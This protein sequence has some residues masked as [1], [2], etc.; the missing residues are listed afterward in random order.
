MNPDA[1]CGILEAMPKEEHRHSRFLRFASLR[2]RAV[3]ALLIVFLPAAAI[4]VGIGLSERSHRIEAV[5]GQSRRLLTAFVAQQDALLDS[6][7]QNLFTLAQDSTVTG[8]DPAACGLALARIRTETPNFANIGV[9]GADG[10]ITCSALPLVEKTSSADRD[11]FKQAVATKRFAVGSYQVGRITGRRALNAA[12]PVLDASGDVRQVV[13]IA[14]DLDWL[15][16][17]AAD[18]GLPD[19]MAFLEVDRGGTVVTRYPEPERYMGMDASATALAQAMLGGERGSVRAT[20]L[21]GKRRT[22]QFAPVGET[23]DARL[24]ASVG[25]DEERV[26]AD[27]DR[28]FSFAFLLLAALGL[29]ALALSL[30]AFRRLLIDPI[31][32]LADGFSRLRGGEYRARLDVPKAHNEMRALAEAFNA[33]AKAMEGHVN[34]LTE[35]DRLIQQLARR[36]EMA[37]RVNRALFRMQDV[38]D[39]FEEACRVGVDVAGFLGAW[40]VVAPPRRAPRVAA[41][42]GIDVASS[43]LLPP[44][45]AAAAHPVARALREGV[46]VLAHEGGRAS[47][48]PPE[49]VLAGAASL[50]AFPLKMDGKPFGAFILASEAA[51]AFHAEDLKLFE[52]LADD[53]AVG[54]AFSLNKAARAHAE[55][56][57][58]RAR[59]RFQ[60]FMDMHPSPAWMT[61]AAG[62][63]VYGN[64]ALRRTLGRPWK[65][66]QGRTVAKLL[67]KKVAETS[68]QGDRKVLES[69]APFNAVEQ[70]TIAGKP[71]TF[72][73]M[74]F[75]IINDAGV[76]LVGGMAF[77]VT[78]ERQTQER[79]TES[80]KR[81]RSYI[82]QSIDGVFVM[83]DNGR[84]VDANPAAR[85]MLGYDEEELRGMSLRDL[86][87]HRLTEEEKLAFLLT[88]IREGRNGMDASVM[89][90]DGT[91]LIA[92]VRII[93]LGGNRN[94][95]IFRDVTERFRSEEKLRELNELKNSFIRIVAHQLR[96]PLNAVRWNLEALME[97]RA[98][99]LHARQRQLLEIT[100]GA[101]VEVIRRIGD[102]LVATDIEE[103]RVTF[104]RERLS[105]TSV[106]SS[107]LTEWKPRCRAK[108]IDCSYEAAK[109]AA[110]AVEADPEKIREA[111]GKLME[112]AIAYSKK[113]G[114][115]AVRL[116][117]VGNR[118]R[119]EVEDEG[120][121]IPEAEQSRIFTR[122]YRA[123]NASSMLPN[124]SGLGLSIAKYFVE[125]HGGS[126]GFLSTEGKGS[127]FWFE[128]PTAK[129]PVRRKRQP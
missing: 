57:L 82:E 56:A 118:V 83:A 124:A 102:L 69:G 48:F 25:I 77:D 98:G 31:R 87:D 86:M 100:H 120:I 106:V 20:G 53:I 17:L 66:I 50:A 38:Q 62:R 2:A 47:G 26:L 37:A 30:Y 90:K 112:N 11:W 46:S 24:Y 84:I 88:L 117:A 60:L 67:G 114:R 8:D 29:A 119:F 6:T 41:A 72:Q 123:S 61:D 125:Q 35:R 110:E 93:N 36:R 126:I 33:T 54:Y 79:L 89:R 4:M 43:V 12:Y 122:F 128:L 16:E 80:E 75:P 64:A 76:R 129:G 73:V 96:T 78:E 55:T 52:E 63:Y 44:G 74:K 14:L 101:E 71:R 3:L 127:L 92:D 18:I 115:V 34:G 99:K 40:I 97:G 23:H 42:A 105:L 81:Y 121:G 113:G 107:V 39:L 28:R 27:I 108:G 94:L 91:E 104:A 109:E 95:G 19:G 13:F 85:S 10:I 70:V 116:S 1:G 21:D 51:A 65:E 59:Q 22:F 45:K 49:L 58:D 15:N 9:V 5:H 68:L 7:R 103:G 32:A 111:A